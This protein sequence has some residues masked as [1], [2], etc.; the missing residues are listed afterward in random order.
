M[1]QNFM[2]QNTQQ[3]S[4]VIKY[5]ILFI[6]SSVYGH[7]G[8]FYFSATVMEYRNIWHLFV[9]T[10][11]SIYLRW[12][13]RNRISR[14]NIEFM[15]NFYTNHQSVFQK[16]LHHFASPQAMNESPPGPTSSP[17]HRTVSFRWCLSLRMYGIPHYSFSWHTG[18]SHV[19][20]LSC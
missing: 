11:T 8:S 15:F 10:R 20:F 2:S 18:F 3:R 13:P 14:L 17:T 7:W 16:Q 1:H 19:A 5:C 6:R 12:I 9:W 4:A